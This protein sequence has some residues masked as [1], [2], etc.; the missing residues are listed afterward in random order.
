V[1][2]DDGDVLNEKK[3]GRNLERDRSAVSRKATARQAEPRAVALRAYLLDRTGSESNNDQSSF[4]TGYLETR[5][6]KT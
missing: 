6:E 5:D 1:K 3:V 4:P 2:T